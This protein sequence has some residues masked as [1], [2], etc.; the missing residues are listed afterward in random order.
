[1]S[2]C[3]TKLRA[4]FIL[5]SLFSFALG[6]FTAPPAKSQ[7]SALDSTQ[8]T[9][10]K[11]QQ[12]IEKVL[13]L[14]NQAYVY[15]QMA[16]KME[17]AILSRLE[18]G[19]YQQITQHQALADKLTADL[20][21]TSHD[22]HLA[23]RAVKKPTQ[24]SAPKSDADKAQAAHHAELQ[25]NYGLER[26][27]VSA[28]D[29]GYFKF[30]RFDNSWHARKE[31]TKM[32]GKVK[33]AKAL[34]FDLTDNLGGSPKMIEFISSFLFDKPTRL[35]LF[36]DR[37]GNEV[38]QSL[39]FTDIPGQRIAQNIPIYVLTSAFTFSAAEEFAYNL[40]SFG[41]AT[42]VGETTG[43][44]AHPVFARKISSHIRVIVPYRRAWNPITK[45]N[46]E[47]VGVIPDIKATAEDA[48]AV[49]TRAALKKIAG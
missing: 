21:H 8:L 14:L 1:M 38:G 9:S 45:T 40:Q 43:G 5:I 46:W 24:T 37:D 2:I 12:T 22:K 13:K 23:V 30:N 25:Q 18:A 28:D 42:I 4:A 20:Q 27:E 44:G 35:N 10:Q 41:R 36:Y 32:L 26:A 17:A 39:T 11:R 47:G 19:E 3:K 7:T 31:V 33:H 34:I 15:P 6:I 29:I 49:A 16:L 48:L